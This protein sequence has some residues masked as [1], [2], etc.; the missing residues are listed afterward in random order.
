MKTYI[1]GKITGCDLDE[2]KAKFKKAE[3]ALGLKGMEPVNPM[4]IDIAGDS[5]TW[6]QYM[7]N[8][9]KELFECSGIYMLSDW[10]ESKGARIEHAIAIEMGMEMFYEDLLT[11]PCAPIENFTENLDVALRMCGI[12]IH[13]TLLDKI[14]DVSGLIT[15][16]GGATSMSDIF[17]LKLKWS[18]DRI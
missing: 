12:E 10:R 13:R 2:A 3:R 9:I 15:K 4:T 5:P 1:S 16:K 8:D 14:V 18:K 11:A 6:E 7:L 17:D